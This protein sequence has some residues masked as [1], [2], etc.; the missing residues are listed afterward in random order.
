MVSTAYHLIGVGIYTVPEA[1]RL[2]R[3]PAARIRRWIGGYRYVSAIT[4]DVRFSPPVV[5]SGLDV[6]AGVRAL[7]FLD[8][9]EVRFVNAFR[10][11][12]VGWKTLRLAHERAQ[13]LVRKSRPFSTG[14]FWTDGRTILLELAQKDAALL[15]IIKNQLALTK[16]IEP[17]LSQ[18]DLEEDQA[19]RWW[20]MGKNRS[21]VVDP[22]RNFGQPIVSKEGVP[23][24]VLAKAH[25][26]ERS[27]ATV[28]R[29]FK[30]EQRSVR[31]ALKFE[32]RLAA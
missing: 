20:P 2:T 26:A 11:R 23:T 14:R 21:V 13:A 18:L 15:D 31:D 3:V 6:I 17:Y 28:A 4:P 9:Q 7:S 27:V 8:L 24:V 1:S 30:V 22:K 25:H 16:I 19:I 29:W 5:P 12:G 10:R 32:R